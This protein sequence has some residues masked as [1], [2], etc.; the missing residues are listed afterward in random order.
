M[1]RPEIVTITRTFLS[2]PPRPADAPRKKASKGAA[3]GGIVQE[4]AAGAESGVAEFRIVIPHRLPASSLLPT[5]SRVW[6]C[7]PHVLSFVDQLAPPHRPGLRLPGVGW[8]RPGSGEQF[9]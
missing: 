6:Q 3:A 5:A 9:R 7:P 4:R 2:S 1:C 8:A